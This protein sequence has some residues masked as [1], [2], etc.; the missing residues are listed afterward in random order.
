[1]TP[2]ML[3]HHRDK[4]A[5]ARS[6]GM[7]IHRAVEKPADANGGRIG[8]PCAKLAVGWKARMRQAIQLVTVITSPRVADVVYSARMLICGACEH[9]TITR[10]GRHW[11]ACCPCPNWSF[12]GESSALESKNWHTRHECPR[13][14]PAFGAV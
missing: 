8:K 9:C 13:P 5:R 2:E 3:Q 11:C 6:R 10:D 7:T 4:V 14:D 1:M 12:A